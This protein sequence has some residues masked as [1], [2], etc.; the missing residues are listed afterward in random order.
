MHGQLLIW[1]LR[2]CSHMIHI[3]I[4][5]ILTLVYFCLQG[6]GSFLLL[7]LP[8]YAIQFCIYEQLRIG[9]K[10][11]VLSPSLLIYWLYLLFILS[12]FHEHT[13]SCFY[14]SEHLQSWILDIG[15]K[16][17]TYIDFVPWWMLFSSIACHR[18]G[19]MIVSA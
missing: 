1:L 7:D 19:H 2:K 11:M 9:Y 14:A 12:Y 18:V 13:C 16:T 3:I 6:Y 15:L 17:H 8:F 10:L 4:L 5:S